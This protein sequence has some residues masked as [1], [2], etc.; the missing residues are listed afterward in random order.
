MINDIKK[1]ITHPLIS[2]QS[3]LFKTAKIGHTKYTR[4]IV[5]SHA[6]SGSNFLISLLNSNLTIEAEGEIMVNV[7]D[8]DPEES[9]NRFFT[10]KRPTYI[11]A[12]GFKVFYYHPLDFDE[13]TFW[14]LLKSIDDLYVIHLKRRNHLRMLTS[15]KLAKKTGKW[16]SSDSVQNVDPSEK[17]ITFTME[18]LIQK[19]EKVE[20][21]E[22]KGKT[23]FSDQKYIAITYEDLVENRNATIEEISAFLG[24]NFVKSSTTLQKQ[25]PE[26][27]EDLITN[28]DDLK[29][30]FSGTRWDKYFE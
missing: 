18:E 20:Y 30:Q 14:S 2:F 17:K 27:L 4:F 5:L 6:R 22:E 26:P 1:I 21:W 8:Q 12:R 15:T 23:Y 16:A 28:Y 29:Q 11:R 13:D 10:K 19:F 25:N 9:L 24:T 7:G 3:L